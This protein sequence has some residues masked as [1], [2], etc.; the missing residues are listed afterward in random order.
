VSYSRRVVRERI[1]AESRGGGKGFSAAVKTSL[2]PRRFVSSVVETRRAR[3]STSLDANGGGDKGRERSCEA[4]GGGR[5]A[6]AQKQMGPTRR[7]TPLSPARGL[8]QGKH[9]APSVFAVGRA[10]RGSPAAGSVTG[11]RTGIRLLSEVAGIRKSRARHPASAETGGSV[12][13]TRRWP[14]TWPEPGC[15]AWRVTGFSRPM[16]APLSRSSLAI[17]SL[18]TEVLGMPISKTARTGAA[19]SIR[20][21]IS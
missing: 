14:R 17:D 10:I 2:A 7:S 20:S 19:I 18:R 16:V 6:N 9:L 11:A 4:V 5:L 12:V 3:I 1:V 13:A 15:F 8:P 21:K